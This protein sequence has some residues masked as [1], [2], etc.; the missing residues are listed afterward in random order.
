[1]KK[2]L[3]TVSMALMVGSF[4]CS[5][6]PK[7]PPPATTAPAGQA[8]SELK[9]DKEKNSYAIGMNIGAGLK[10]Q[11][12]EIDADSLARGIRD[13]MAGKTAM[14]LDQAQGTL[15]ALGE[16][17]NTKRQKE[18]AELSEKNK[19]EGDAFLA[20]NKTKEGV[21]TLPSGLQYKVLKQGTGPKPKAEDIVTTN[22]KGTLVDGTEFD[23]SYTR[24]EPARFEVGKVIEGWKEA[25]QLMA[26]GSKWQ[27]FVPSNLAYG[28]RQ[29]GDKIGPN[30]VLVFEVEL[31]T[32]EDKTKGAQTQT[33]PE[34]H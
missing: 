7:N 33:K 34:K 27:L 5:E 24:G 4:A 32:I 11:G 3:L 19:K 15:K 14:T 1:M 6:E 30:S 9:T 29:M 31:L 10:S 16:Q 21:I 13:M 26:V 2:I 23:S 20:A 18:M 28:E 8:A 12:I 25:L 22:Y 17:I